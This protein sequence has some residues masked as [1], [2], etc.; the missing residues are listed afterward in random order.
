MEAEGRKLLGLGYVSPEPFAKRYEHST[1]YNEQDD[2][3]QT[4][5]QHA[6]IATD[7]C[8]VQEWVRIPADCSSANESVGEID[9]WED[10]PIL[11]LAKSKIG[12]GRLVQP[13]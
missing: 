8:A 3:R 12:F 5:E 4:I 7:V 9:Q 1:D 11:Y 10:Q 6:R 13:V 2:N